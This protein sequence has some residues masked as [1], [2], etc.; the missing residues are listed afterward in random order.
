MTRARNLSKLSNPNVFTVD[1]SNNVGV[2]SS[3]PDVKL[4]VDG[5]AHIGA[6]ITMYSTS[7]IVSATSFFGDGSSLSGITSGAT[8]GAASGS[9]RVVV[10]SLTSGTMTD[11]GTDVDLAWNSTTNTLSAF[12]INVSG[13][14]TYEDVTNVDSLGI[15]TARTGIKVAAGGIDVVG[16]GLTVTGVSTFSDGINVVGG[17]L[18]V[19]GVSTFSDDVTLIGATAN[20]TFDKSDNAVL[21][22]DD[23]VLKF[24]DGADLKIYHNGANSIIQDVGTGDLRIAGNVVKINNF[25]NT[26]T[27][28][29]ATEGS[30][31]VINHNNSKKFETTTNGVTITGGV[32]V[33]SGQS[34]GANG[35]TAVYYGDGSNLTSLDADSLDGQSLS[36]DSTANTVV[37]RTANSDINVRLVRQTFANQSTISGGMVFRINE[38]SDNFLRVCNS[39]SAI[40]TFLGVSA[41]GADTNYL[42]ATGDDSAAGTITFNGAVNIR[43][44]LDF[45]DG[46]VLRMGSSDDFT[47]T[48]NSNGWNYIN[49][50]GNG[51]IFQDTGSAVMR[52]EDSGNFRPEDDESGQL[53]LS[54]KRWNIVYASNIRGQ[55][56][57]SPGHNNTTTGFAL[58]NDATDNGGQGYFSSSGGESIYCN[59]NENGGIVRFSRA[60]VEN[61]QIVMNT[62][63]VSY[64]TTSDYRLKE[65]VV[66][67]ENGI[68]RVKQLK[69]YRFNFMGDPEVLDGFL[70]HEAQVVVP[71]SVS[72]TQDEVEIWKESE[73]L[74][75]GVSVGDNKLDEQGNT[76]PVYQGID[77][78]KIV[79]LLTAALQEAISKI[80]TLETKVAALETAN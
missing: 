65:N 21:F 77:Q 32:Q 22:A 40:R 74:P 50:K 18:T 48:F 75:D 19:T 41:T 4:D 30:S 25:N 79:P 29:K 15:V 64:E 71:E 34:F 45:A 54:N 31:V 60:G 16:G 55:S 20:V 24:G 27:M 43:S 39:T 63:S 1:T 61:G 51:I 10:T 11:A 47:V 42:S 80:E 38:S 76:I 46:D 26:A 17:G 44:A 3:V 2:G 58:K 37:G 8:L 6:A 52:L 62:S 49:L 69:P 14:L 13:T 78:G 68:E 9:Q 59:R 5:D 70:A 35:P 23:A 73:E 72:G 28:I 56:S 36:S 12:N 66:A 67:L 57:G 53:G 33:G 7:G